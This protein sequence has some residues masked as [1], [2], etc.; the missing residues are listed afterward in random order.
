MNAKL[1]E[2]HGMENGA[3]LT[4]KTQITGKLTT[5][6]ILTAKLVAEDNK[7]LQQAVCFC[8]LF[9][10]VNTPLYNSVT[11]Q[12]RNVASLETYFPLD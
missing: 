8:L 11:P 6:E 1:N 4:Q 2:P 5:E 10:D 7:N 12:F 9:S 3:L